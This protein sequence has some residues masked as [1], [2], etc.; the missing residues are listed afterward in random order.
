MSK[1]DYISKYHALAVEHGHCASQHFHTELLIQLTKIWKPKVIVETGTFCGGSFYCWLTAF[2]D[3]EIDGHVYTIDI[4]DRSDKLLTDHKNLYTH[5]VGDAKTVTIDKP[6]DFLF[7]DDDHRY[8]QVMALWNHFE[9]QINVGG[10]IMFHDP[11]S[12]YPEPDGSPCGVGKAVAELWEKH[13]DRF[14]R[15]YDLGAEKNGD[16]CGLEIW[17]KLR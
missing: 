10:L 1:A 8:E 5:I 7:L 16:S 2:I 12:P 13:K 15:L 6:I 4:V 17:I 9:S 3:A 14:V 11:I